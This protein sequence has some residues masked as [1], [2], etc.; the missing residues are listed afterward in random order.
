MPLASVNLI[1]RIADRPWPGCQVKLFGMMVT[2]MS[3][4][5]AAMVLA[6]LFLVAVVILLARRRQAVPRGAA[7][8]LE[9]IVYFVR[10]MIARPALHEQAERFTPMLLTLFLFILAVNLMG[11]LPLEA[12]LGL[13]PGLPR[14]GGVAT[15][16]PAVTGALAAMALVTIVV[17]GLSRQARLFH[18][19]PGVPK[20]VCV[21]ISPVL[22]ILSLSPKVPG[23]AGV[24]L[25]LPLGLLELVGVL[26]KCMALMIRLFA[27]M[28]L[29]ARCCWRC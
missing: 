21:A 7:N 5:I 11:I 13:V 8:V 19:R 27:N 3:S 24:I 22:W 15:A 29:R 6:G 25:A 9:V 17:L 18:R 10:D 16:L 4:C 14:I 20:V 12:L 26:T 23:V 2:L 28:L 1:D